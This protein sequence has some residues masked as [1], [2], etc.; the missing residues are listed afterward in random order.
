MKALPLKFVTHEI[1][2]KNTCSL[3][4]FNFYPYYLH[5][6]KNCS[7][8]LDAVYNPHPISP[9]KTIKC[10][11]GKREHVETLEVSL[12]FTV[13]LFHL[14]FIVEFFFLCKSRINFSSV[15]RDVF[16]NKNL[17]SFFDF[18]FFVLIFI[19]HT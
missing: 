16:T 17:N 13:K 15:T 3:L 9:F 8:N 5:F 4:L 11:D 18:I 6:Y 19:H 2:F 1:D 7:L 14:P 12:P 10:L